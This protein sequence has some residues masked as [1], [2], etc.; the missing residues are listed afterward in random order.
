MTEKVSTDQY[1]RKTWNVDLYAEEAKNKNKRKEPSKESILAVEGLKS[2]SYNEHRAQLIES[3][4]SA[5]QKHTLINAEADP[6]AT[7][8]KNKRFG[9]FCPICDLS[10][11]D[12]L[13]LVDHI[14]SPQHSKRAKALA[15]ASG[16]SDENEDIG[17]V[18][19]ASAQE[20][21]EKI[22]ELVKKSIRNRSS[23]RNLGS[24]QERIQKRQEFEE[25]KLRKRREK[26]LRKRSNK[27]EISDEVGNS[28]L[29]NAMGFQGF[30]TTKV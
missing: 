8:G 9:F 20:V 25:N 19:R 4:V 29:Q 18:K 1:G 27:V 23:D 12:T 11:R 15:S 30:G 5:V 16:A 6:T 13:A 7:Y 3:S 17:G 26:K 2:E 14:N 28:E 10:F 21:A 22:E 24:I